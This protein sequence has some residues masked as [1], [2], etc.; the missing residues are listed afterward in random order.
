MSLGYAGRGKHLGGRGLYDGVRPSNL[1][2]AVDRVTTLVIGIES[3]ER[4]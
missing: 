1:K 3:S 4:S 2:R